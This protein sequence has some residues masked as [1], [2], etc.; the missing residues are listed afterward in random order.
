MDLKPEPEPD[1]L[2]LRIVS[3]G[4]SEGTRV[5]DA[6]TGR[7]LAGVVR[8]AW[9]AGWDSL[10]RQ[11]VVRLELEQVALD[12]TGEGEITRLPDWPRH[13]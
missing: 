7:A 9:E 1:K 3:D 6:A 13:E 2:R 8:V 4:T 12:L 5:L 10:G 11:P